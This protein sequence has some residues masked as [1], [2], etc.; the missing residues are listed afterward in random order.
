[1]SNDKSTAQILA[2]FRFSV[3]GSLLTQPPPYGEIKAAIRELAEKEWLHPIFKDYRKFA[4]GTIGRWYYTARKARIDSVAVLSTK[5]RSDTGTTRVLEEKWQKVLDDQYQ[6]HKSW[7]WQIHADNLQKLIKDQEDY[8]YQVPSYDTVR[9]YMKS[10]GYFP[11]KRVRGDSRD[12]YNKSQNI[13]SNFERRSFDMPFVGSLF[14]FDFHTAKNERQ[15][16]TKSGQYITPI[17][18]GIIDNCSRLICHL[19]WYTNESAE[20]LA[21]GL[22][23]AILKRGMPRAVYSDNGSAMKSAEINQ[24]L[25]RLGVQYL[26]TMDYSPEQNGKIERFWSTLEGR[27]MAMLEN[28]KD[29]TL[30]DLNRY[31][32]AWVEQ[33]YNKKV[34]SEIKTSPFEKFI[35]SKKVLRDSPT[36][37]ELV[38]VFRR[39]TTRRQRQTDSTISVE[40]IRFEV[41][42]AY[43]H[44]RRITIRYSHWE[45][46]RVH[47]VDPQN[48]KE[49]CQ[50][51]PENRVYNSSGERRVIHTDTSSIS[52]PT[53]IKNEVAPLLEEM[54]QNMSETGLPLHF[55]HK[56]D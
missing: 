1:M 8:S 10:K 32:T 29:L 4:A 18:L 52:N 7:S 40:G 26:K 3:V 2:E 34:H 38:D 35:N 22:T 11:I 56:E 36:H 20:E 41:P 43:K 24:G 30:F 5:S 25:L 45:P 31:T 14:Q 42:G 44:M 50:L 33:E 23:Q 27:L 48:G 19:Q 16:L 53:E 21:H 51:F 13:K 6:Q 39:E 37:H 17:A 12:N 28:K 54:L 15:V 47:M 46:T 49:I 9:R 55:M